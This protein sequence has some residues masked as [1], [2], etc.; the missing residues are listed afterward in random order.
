MRLYTNNKGEWV[1][2]QA[3]AKKLGSFELVEVPTDKPTLLQFLN[4]YQV[5]GSDVISAQMEM[6][7]QQPRHP[8]SCS[9]NDVSSYD[10][11][12]V[13][14]NCPKQHLGNALAAIISRLNDQLGEV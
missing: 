14:L 4:E 3:D 8:L 12:D 13:V 11:R 5:G 2:T 9:A 1:G 6:V 10:V 7:Q